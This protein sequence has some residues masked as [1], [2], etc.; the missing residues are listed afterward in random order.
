[1]KNRLLSIIKGSIPYIKELRPIAGSVTAVI[2]WQQLDYWFEKYP[3]GFYKF[4][5]PPENPHPSYKVG[6][7]WEEELGFSKD[8]F[9]TA[10]DK[11]GVRHSSK[12]AFNKVKN[13][14]QKNEKE[15][16]F[17]S[18][19][20]KLKKM[21]FY[22]RNHD[23]ADKALTELV[24]IHPKT[25]RKTAVK[26]DTFQSTIDRESQSTIDRDCRG[27]EMDNPNLPTSEMPIYPPRQ[28]QPGV[29]EITSE[30][31]SETTTTNKAVVAAE[32]IELTEEQKKCWKW[33]K[34][35][36]FWSSKVYSEAAFLKHYESESQALKGQYQNWLEL[37]KPEEA[38]KIKPKHPEVWERLGFKSKK[39]WELDGYNK[40][41]AKYAETKT[42]SNA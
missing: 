24:T 14:F 29:T 5:S 10:F 37:N 6:D 26:N 39:E 20:D 36:E 1:M 2:L 31:T 12:T 13:P 15:M 27:G 33:A 34:E 21:T 18:Y 19:Q 32:K 41:M 16:F 42:G 7:S 4:L 17:A 3:D 38:K 28:S 8:E 22:Y 23:L 35:N 9:R 11:I 25:K 40:Q 30:I